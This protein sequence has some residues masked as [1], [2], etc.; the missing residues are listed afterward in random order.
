MSRYH[1]PHPHYQPV[2]L[3]PGQ[4]SPIGGTWRPAT[5]TDAI[6]QVHRGLACEQAGP[7]FMGRR[8]RGFRFADGQLADVHA[9]AVTWAAEE[10]GA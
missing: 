7:K 6:G 1:L 5:Y 2:P 9:S 8:L 3:A 4:R 10:V